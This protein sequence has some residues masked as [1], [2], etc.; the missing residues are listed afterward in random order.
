MLFSSTSLREEGKRACYIFLWK[1]NIS[2]TFIHSLIH[3]TINKHLLSGKDVNKTQPQSSGRLQS[4]GK[5]TQ[6]F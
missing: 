3:Y 5:E 2:F 6:F 1:W 4:S